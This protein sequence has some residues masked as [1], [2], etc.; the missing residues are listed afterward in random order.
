MIFSSIFFLFIFLPIVLIIYYISPK[1]IKN[2]M[3]LIASIFFYAWGEPIY[4]ILMVFS[5]LFN[6]TMGLDINAKS[7]KPKSARNALIFAI[8]V[9]LFI[10]G[11]FKY[12]GFL[13]ESIN[14]GLHLSLTYKKLPLPIGISFYT[15]QTLSYIIDV[16]KKKVNVQKNVL[17]FGLFVTMFPQ[18]IAGP[19]VRYVDI[20]K[21]LKA[22]TIT[23]K[24]FS[25]GAEYFIKGL[26]KKVLLANNIGMLFETMKTTPIG[27]LSVVMA[28]LGILAFTFQ[29]YF[30][31]SGY[32][33]MAIGLGKMF[34]FEFMQN[35]NYPYQSIS[36][37]DF[38]RRWHISLSSWFKEYVYIPLGGSR[39]T[40]LKHIRNLLIVW[41]LTGLW[42]GASW[43]FVVWGLYYGVILI[44][45]KYFLQRFIE[46]M[47]HFIS[48]S[49]TFLIV[50]IG[51][52]FFSS[53]NLSGAIEVL[54][55]MFGFGGAGFIDNTAI[56]YLQSYIIMIVACIICSRA[57]SYKCYLNIAKRSPTIPIVI[58][59][60]IFILCISFLVFDTYNP[61][62]YF[63]F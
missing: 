41:T 36:V 27:E 12:Y 59:I 37:S 46:K 55:V 16:Y 32:S 13:V 60:V 39:V 30:D 40:V 42:H 50:M 54:K 24:K 26:A 19:I 52:V 23:F 49:Y 11:F 3:L 53:E 18:L 57:G 14:S 35:F 2:V 56:Y 31:F 7:E 5:V 33:D 9:N 63:R 58:N 48:Q 10:L 20:E 17:N 8:V 6:Y 1:A 21:Q 28:W 62:L 44:I 43:N 34:G 15:F 4:V 22:R 45:E 61:F 25:V 47:P 51:W 38:W 29:I